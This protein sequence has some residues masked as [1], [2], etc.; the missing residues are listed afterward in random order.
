[1]Q[2][3]RGA[4][5]GVVNLSGMNLGPALPDLRAA[6]DASGANWW[7]VR[8]R[9]APIGEVFFR[10]CTHIGGVFNDVHPY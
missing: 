9:C 2:V 7:E 1:M 5:T 3:K 6:L 10:M 8:D 4:D